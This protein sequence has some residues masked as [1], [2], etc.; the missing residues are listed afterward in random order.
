M[1]RVQLI[2]E[3]LGPLLIETADPIGINDVVFIIKR[4]DDFEGVIFEVDLDFEFIEQGLVYIATAFETA[5]GPDAEVFMNIYEYNPNTY[6]WELFRAGQISFTK[7]E[8]TDTRVIVNAD[9]TGFQRRTMNLMDTDVNMETLVSQNGN[10]LPANTGIF[11]DVTYHS[12]AILKELNASPPDDTEYLQTDVLGEGYPQCITPGGCVRGFN[13]TAYGQVDFSKAV[14]SELQGV[15]QTPW[16]YSSDGAFPIYQAI[17]AGTMRLDVSLRLKHTVIPFRT[18]GS[19]EFCGGAALDIPNKHVRA[20]FR[21]TDADDV[22]KDEYSF[23]EWM[24]N[25]GCGADGAVGEFETLTYSD[26]DLVIDIGDK[27]YIYFTWELVGNYEQE[28][29]A[30]AGRIDYGFTVQADLENTFIRMVQ[31]TVAPV[32]QVKTVM[33]YEAIERCVQFYSD[34]IDCF[35]STLLGRTDILGPDGLPLYEQDGDY[36]LIGITSGNNLR[37]RDKPVLENLQ[38]LLEFVNSIAC[39]GFGFKI[40]DGK[41]YFVLERRAQFYDVN[42]KVLSLK[43][44]PDVK[45]KIDTKRLYNLFQFGYEGKLDIGSVNAIDEINTPRSY[46]IPVVNTKSKLIASTKMRT[47]GY[48]IEFQRRLIS[49]TEES[50]LDDE[51]FSVVLLRDGDTFKTKKNEG[52]AE[53]T[54]VFDPGSVYNI[55]ITPRRNMENW[56]P[57]IASSLIRSFSKVITFSSGEVNYTASTRKVGELEPMFENGPVDLTNIIPITDYMTLSF[58]VPVTRDE[59][60]LLRLNP[61]GYVEITD[62][63]GKIGEGFISAKGIQYNKEDETADF[64]LMKKYR[65]N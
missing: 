7:Y 23:G 28:N 11:A 10:A 2:N 62:E 20:W 45:V 54:G 63:Y 16:G 1:L 65:K 21:H 29:G 57:F 39:I 27:L 64:D 18:G 14:I 53:I 60:A 33:I 58:S 49:S 50:K 42:N 3:I 47:S 4:S 51:T 37:G 35:R 6:K 46:R 15:F 59:L 5:G 34:Q 36:S 56:L 40:I 13:Q 8:L 44:V 61:E 17:E 31:K 9:Q 12:K 25:L 52:Y 24:S 32:T 22:I 41:Q 26:Y 55:D 48:Q 43:N 19:I 38:A 30:F